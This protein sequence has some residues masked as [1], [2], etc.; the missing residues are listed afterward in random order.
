MSKISSTCPPT[1][2]ELLK[3]SRKRSDSHIKLHNVIKAACQS[4]VY[5]LPQNKI[6]DVS[7]LIVTVDDKLY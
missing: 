2:S 7:K 4:G 6:S 1:R 3:T 5:P